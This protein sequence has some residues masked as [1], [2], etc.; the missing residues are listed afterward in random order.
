MEEN[1]LKTKNLTARFGVIA[2]LVGIVFGVMLYFADLHY[3]RSFAIQSIQFAILGVFVVIAA[4]QFK[5]ANN[6]YI[7]LGQAIKIG[8]GVGL[9]AALLGTLYFLVL[10]NVIEPDYLENATEIQRIKT[11]EENPGITQEQWD[12]GVAFQKKLFPVF[13]AFG[14]VISALFGLIVGLI[15]GLIIKKEEPA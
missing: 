13:L 14:L 2:G 1:K 6:G 15:T 5:K 11:F 4:I 9:I 3:D 8:A 12:Q 7:K 10:S